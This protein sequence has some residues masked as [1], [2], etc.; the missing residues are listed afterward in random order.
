MTEL[1]RIFNKNN[2]VVIGAVHFP[3]LIGYPDFPGIKIAET[4]ALRDLRSFEHGGADGTIFENNYDQPHVVEVGPGTSAAMAY[5]GSKIIDASQKPVGVSTLW[6]DFKTSLAIAK[7]LKLSFIRIPVF[8]DTVRASCGVIHG[9]PQEIIKYRRALH[10]ENVALFT[11]IHVKH[12]ELL[13]RYSIIQSARRAIAS[14]SDALILTGKWTGDAPDLNEL[15]SVRVAVGNF[16]ILIGSGA[17]E[18]NAQALFRYANGVIVST[19]LK[20][21]LKKK[22][23]VNVK[24]YD[25]RIDESKVRRFYAGLR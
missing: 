17:D 10:A 8:V 4:N 12:A 1:K 3:P 20:R 16:P 9:N 5:L 14:G 2:N 6:N 7:L 25:Q 11:D 21:G 18:K 23:E 24:S 15:K 22:N 19:S 13:S